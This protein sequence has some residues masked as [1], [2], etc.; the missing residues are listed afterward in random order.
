MRA[1]TD[2]KIDPDRNLVF[3]LVRATEAAAMDCA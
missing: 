1:E 3:E 2:G